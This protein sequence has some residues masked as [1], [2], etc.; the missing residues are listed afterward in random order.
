MFFLWCLTLVGIIGCLGL[1]CFVL[2]VIVLIVCYLLFAC[3]CGLGCLRLLVGLLWFNL[4]GDL[5]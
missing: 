4:L 5:A 2:F 3:F 1:S